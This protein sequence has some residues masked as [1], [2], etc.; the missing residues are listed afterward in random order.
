MG[1]R[2][3]PMGCSGYWW[4]TL[5]DGWGW[6]GDGM[7]C[8]IHQ[9]M[10][11]IE[12]QFTRCI[13]LYFKLNSQLYN[14]FKWTGTKIKWWRISHLD[15]LAGLVL[16]QAWWLAGSSQLCLAL[17]I[18]CWLDLCPTWL[19]WTSPVSNLWL[20]HTNCFL[21]S[22]SK[23]SK[24]VSPQIK[25]SDILSPLSQPNVPLWSCRLEISS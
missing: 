15:P 8:T 4:C 24:L 1:G 10:T 22:D 3:A 16:T 20:A 11:E 13:S 23:V 2:Y 6:L 9:Y 7:H 19:P 14:R 18:R 25:I 5:G 17:P 12:T 21:L